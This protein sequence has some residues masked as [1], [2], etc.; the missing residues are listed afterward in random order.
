MKRVLAIVLLAVST[1]LFFILPAQTGQNS[2]NNTQQSVRENLLSDPNQKSF[3][4]NPNWQRG[5]VILQDN[6]SITGQAYRYNVYTDQ[7]EFVSALSPDAVKVVEVDSKKFIHTE[8]LT[9]NNNVSRGYFELIEDGQMKL[10]L[11]RQMTLTGSAQQ[12]DHYASSGGDNRVQET[13]YIK[14][15]DEP[16]ERINLRRR[17]VIDFFS[18]NPIIQEYFDNNTFLRM[19]DSR[20]ADII[21]YYNE[22][23]N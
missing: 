22:N 15:N 21:R 10:L 5:L 6:T 23:V 9:D 7:I 18:E 14:E 17:H 19:N 16:A 1:V 4:L 8:F 3:F 13:Y 2:N 12:A 11:R 20:I